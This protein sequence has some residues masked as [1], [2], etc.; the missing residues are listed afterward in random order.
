[1]YARIYPSLRALSLS[2]FRK[3]AGR[4]VCGRLHRRVARGICSA[5]AAA[6]SA[7]G[8]TSAHPRREAASGRFGVITVAR[9]TRQLRR[10]RMPDSSR[11]CAQ[12][13]EESGIR[14]LRSCLVPLATV[15]TPNLPEAASLLGWAEVEPGAEEAAARAEQIPRATLR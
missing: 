8:S 2:S 11:S 12:L 1:M 15:I 7:P 4:I 6:S 9:G 5:R 14:T 10:V 3:H 13:L